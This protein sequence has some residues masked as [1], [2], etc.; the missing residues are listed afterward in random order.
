MSPKFTTIEIHSHTFTSSLEVT[1]EIAGSLLGEQAVVF[2]VS[3]R[4][5]AA[6]WMTNNLLERTPAVEEVFEA[7]WFNE[8]GE[9]RWVRQG[10]SGRGAVMTSK[11]FDALPPIAAQLEFPHAVA[12][13]KFRVIER[14][15]RCWGQVASFDA[16]AGIAFV[17]DARIG[18]LSL[19]AMGQP[20][21][22]DHL[23]IH[24]RELVGAVSEGNMR[25]VDELLTS[26]SNIAPNK[27][28][29]PHH[30]L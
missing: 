6:H 8:S 19:P 20:K 5:W 9:I 27:V 12:P 22:T 15:Y 25:V 7:R 30:A 10:S 18:T 13:K 3:P 21:V 28:K 24:A 11:D 17:N 1:H 23:Y 29:Q 2:L 4:S 26:V 14:V 16:D